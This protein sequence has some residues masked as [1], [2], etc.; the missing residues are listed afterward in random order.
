MTAPVEACIE[1]ERHSQTVKQEASI[2]GGGGDSS[3]FQ[4]EHMAATTIETPWTTFQSLYQNDD[5]YANALSSDHASFT[6]PS[7]PAPSSMPMQNNYQ[8]ETVPEQYE[9]GSYATSIASWQTAYNNVHTPQQQMYIEQDQARPRTFPN[10]DLDQVHF[11]GFNG[12]TIVPQQLHPYDPPRSD[13]YQYVGD[14]AEMYPQQA[15]R[16]TIEEMSPVHQQATGYD[17]YYQDDHSASYRS[18]PIDDDIGFGD[19]DDL[20]NEKH[21]PYAKTLYRCLRDAPNHTM[22]LRDIYEWFKTNTSRGKEPHEKG[23]QNSIRHNL[24]MNQ[25]STFSAIRRTCD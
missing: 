2:P 1:F 20:D 22:V 8:L 17:D 12:N 9:A 13:P 3:A 4:H 14:E 19:D 23:W 21:E 6:W 11:S 15:I 16:E 18:T 7:S 24:S 5:G 25:V 10:V